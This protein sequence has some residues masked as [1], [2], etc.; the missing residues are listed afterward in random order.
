MDEKFCGM[1]VVGWIA[2]VEIDGEV[3]TVE[4]T[5]RAVLEKIVKSFGGCVFPLTDV[6]VR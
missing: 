3:E 4:S 6:V 1:K 2:F 5:S